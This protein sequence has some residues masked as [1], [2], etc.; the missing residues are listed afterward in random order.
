[1]LENLTDPEG[2]LVHPATPTG[3]GVLVLAGSSGRIETG[4]ARLLAEAGAT[5]MS[6]R[7]FGGPGQPPG[8]HDVPLES[9]SGAL[10][11]LA[12]SCDRLVVVGTS[13]GAEAALLTAVH[14]DR[15]DAVAALAPSSVVW[16]GIEEATGRVT[17]HWT[18]AGRPLAHVPFVEDWAPD[19]DPPA[20]V[21][22]YR[23]SL[24]AHPD[25]AAAI[26]VERIR[27]EVLLVAGGD[28]RVWPSEL[29]AAALAARRDAAGLDTTVLTRPDAGHRVV[30]PGETPVTGGHA[31][32]RG[33][34]PEADAALGAAA[35]PHLLRLLGTPG[36]PAADAP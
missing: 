2:V 13:F 1:V 6:I 7:W 4:R 11:R 12:A 22:L 29:F 5:A 18:L 31:M 8:P 26:P 23:R 36:R 14:D 28:D 35:W 32:A 19:T 33:G 10:D 21:D 24:A 15:V 16:A 20:Y 30:L 17:S 27:G 3:C 34:T 9:F 25:P